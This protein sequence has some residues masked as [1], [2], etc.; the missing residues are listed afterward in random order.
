MSKLTAL[1]GEAPLRRDVVVALGFSGRRSAAEACLEWTADARVGAVAAEAV[2]AITGISIAGALAREPP[3]ATDGDLPGLEEDLATS[4]MPGP[5]DELP[6]AHAE[7]LRRRW[8]EL[9]PDLPAGRLLRGQPFDLAPVLRELREGPARRRAPLALELAVRSKGLVQVE[10][11]ALTATQ[12][13]QLDEARTVR[14][15]AA[16][17]AAWD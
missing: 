4:L 10:T 17:T 6:L 8:E 14:G 5:D 12:R 16:F 3:P 2:S 11:L 13:S 7:L 9:R 1:L 15:G